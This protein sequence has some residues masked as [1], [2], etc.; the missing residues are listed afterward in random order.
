MTEE[1]ENPFVKKSNEQPTRGKPGRK[2]MTPNFDQVISAIERGEYDEDLHEMTAA[3]RT[4]NTARQ[5]HVLRLV[6]EVFGDDATIEYTKSMGDNAEFTR[7]SMGLGSG[8]VDES[9]G[10]P[11]AGGLFQP[12]GGD[13]GISEDESAEPSP[14]DPNSGWD[15]V[16]AQMMQE[17]QTDPNA[18][19]TGAQVPVQVPIEARSSSV[20][21][22]SPSDMGA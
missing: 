11:M 19:I 22:L 5:E 7:S 15:A 16:E 1:R 6:T 13:S 17:A 3:I 20:G 18:S 12:T 8:T 4:R 10:A 2:P 21:G 9:I 14:D